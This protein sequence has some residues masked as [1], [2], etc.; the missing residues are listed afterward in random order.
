MSPYQR[1]TQYYTNFYNT[2]VNHRTPLSDRVE[3]NHRKIFI[4]PSSAGL[5]F[6][7][8]VA[9]LWLLATNYENNLI[10]S[11]CFLQIALFVAAMHF[12]HA[13][14]S[15]ITIEPVRAA[16]VFAGEQAAIELCISQ[17]SGKLRDNIQLWFD[18]NEAITV[19]VHEQGDSFVTL[20]ATAGQRGRLI[21]GLLR[22]RSYYPLGLMRVWT[23]VRFRFDAVVYPIPIEG[24]PQ[25]GGQGS[26]GEGHYRGTDG[27]DEYVGL[28]SYQRGE[29]LRHIAWKQ[30]AREQ[31]LWSKQYADP[32]EQR[33]WVDWDAFPGM[34]REQRLSRMCW[35]VCELSEQDAIYGL[36]LPGIELPPGRG[37]THRNA[38]LRELALFE[39]EAPVEE[40]PNA[41]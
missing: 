23:Y 10:F 4:F 26:S 40:N 25:A 38:V 1:F 14:L 32:V 3:L 17:R 36:R 7:V 39:V 19:A 27:S 30:Y 11:L 31:G 2:A 12:S 35:Q 37:I 20:L 21:P 22:I 29:S 28:K 9:L 33:Q 34:H 13:N 15:G 24:T 5:V 18:G 16:S 6:L 41:G 8:L